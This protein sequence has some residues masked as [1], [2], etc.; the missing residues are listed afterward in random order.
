M[1]DT[2]ELQSLFALSPEETEIA[3]KAFNAVD[4][5]AIIDGFYQ[6]YTSHEV[7]APFFQ[8]QDIDR[9]KSAQTTHWD[10]LVK[11]GATESFFEKTM[12][13]GAIHEKIG[14]NP[15]IY[16]SGYA[17]VFEELLNQVISSLGMLE[18]SKRKK[19]VG[20]Y[21]RLLMM[22]IAAS[23]TA[24]IDKV[25]DTNAVALNQ[26]FIEGVIGTAVEVSMSM[27][28]VFMDGLKTGQI[29]FEVDHQVNSISAAI[30]EMSATVGTITS[31]TEQALEY[32]K[33]ASESAGQGRQVSDSAMKNM[34]T[35][36]NAVM[37]TSSKA[38]NLSESSKKI[39]QILCK[40]QDIADQTNLLALNATIEAARAGDAGKGFAVVANE[41][42]SLSNETSQ[43]TQEISDIIN[44]FVN[45]IQEIVESMQRVDT[46]VD[47][48][49]EVTEQ[50]KMRMD[51]IEQHANQVRLSMDEISGALTEQSQASHEISAASSTILSSSSHN[52][53]MS[54]K[55]IMVGRQSGTTV[56]ELITSLSGSAKPTSKL[57]LNLAKSD[58]LIWVR[59]VTDM[60]LG[61][62]AMKQEELSDHTQC[63]LGKWYYDLGKAEFGDTDIFKKLEGPHANIHKLGREA[64]ELH[65]NNQHDMALEKLAQMEEISEI[66]VDMLNQLG[67][68]IDD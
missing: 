36:K 44:E 19:L 2:K 51:E 31:N 38:S 66:I 23:M 8:A 21:T 6:K 42:K 20:A 10:V 62:N 57:I 53:E 52:K 59:K 17:Y 28:K 32:T 58:H 63:R 30:E 9:L 67:D 22:D 39:E 29:A 15:S 27:N 65:N 46:A 14:I 55:S 37:E 50:V 13:I 60:L 33:N 16:L 12:T 11:E 25:S 61:G 34:V 4:T 54:E 47:S 1:I 49:Q 41:V 48:G 35:I 40:I 64:F 68:M 24:Y 43:A 45:S 7:T 3:Q 26:S 5:S 18:K 56:V